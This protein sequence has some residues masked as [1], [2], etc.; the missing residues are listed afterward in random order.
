M[1]IQIG[2]ETYLGGCVAA[3]ALLGALWLWL[4]R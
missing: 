3:A 1:D 2:Y 4:S